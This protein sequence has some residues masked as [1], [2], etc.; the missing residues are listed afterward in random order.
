M[1]PVT[2]AMQGI[3]SIKIL[4]RLTTFKNRRVYGSEKSQFIKYLM[5]SRD[6]VTLVNC[7][8]S[9]TW[10][11]HQHIHP[12]VRKKNDFYETKYWYWYVQNLQNLLVWIFVVTSSEELFSYRLHVIGVRFETQ[13]FVT[14]TF[15][16]SLHIIVKW[17]R[18]AFIREFTLKFNVL[19][20]VILYYEF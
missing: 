7:S 8:T 9:S 1:R 13:F 20:I 3:I 4:T 16:G 17:H 19:K 11:P 6:P 2:F 15:Y 10:Q 14:G 12:K 5:T 18:E